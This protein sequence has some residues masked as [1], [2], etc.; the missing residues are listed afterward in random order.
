M[1]YEINIIHLYPDLL[2]LYGDKG[3]IACLKKRLEWREIQ[4]NVTECTMENPEI[5]FESADIIFLGGGS[6]H[7]QEIVLNQLDGRKEELKAYVEKGGCLIATCGGYPM[8]GRYYKTEDK[9]IEGLDI[10]N[11]HSEIDKKR[12]IGNVVLENDAFRDKIVG[13]ENHPNRTF[14]GEHTPLGRVVLGSGNA[15]DS[16]YEGVLYKNVVATYL[17]GPL[18]PKNPEI[19]DFILTRA[20]NR[21]YED[22]GHLPPLS[23]ELETLANNSIIERFCEK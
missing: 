15:E 21:K 11:I 2:N 7:E 22:F 20:L 13:F 4:A 17:H 16:G 10:L 19:C 14:I 1:K 5:D 9:T 3:N 8:L 12:L 18:L 23:D 6:D